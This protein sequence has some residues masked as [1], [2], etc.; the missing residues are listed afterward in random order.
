M[1]R[2]RRRG[3]RWNTPQPASKLTLVA[4]AV[5][6]L[7]PDP[8]FE[9]VTEVVG[10]VGCTNVAVIDPKNW[11]EPESTG[12]VACPRS[13]VINEESPEKTTPTVMYW[14]LIDVPTGNSLNVIVVDAAVVADTDC[15]HNVA[16]SS[17][18]VTWLPPRWSSP[19]RSGSA[20]VRSLTP[21]SRGRVSCLR[22]PRRPRF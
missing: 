19:G 6:P 11:G 12:D 8:G 17:I 15:R 14:L 1:E 3:C 21:A 4:T 18:S 2:D 5:G 7:F 22:G 9:A 16:S 13:V 20:S 10:P